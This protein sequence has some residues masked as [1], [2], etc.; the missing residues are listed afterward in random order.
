MVAGV[1]IHA[2]RN[3]LPASLKRLGSPRVG[4]LLLHS[5]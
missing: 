5:S 2:H 3:P 4:V 1:R